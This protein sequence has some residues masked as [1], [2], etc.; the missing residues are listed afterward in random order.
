MAR[1][2]DE[3]LVF[4]GGIRWQLWR[5]WVGD[6]CPCGRKNCRSGLMDTCDRVVVLKIEDRRIT[7]WVMRD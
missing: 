6:K 2:L 5:G 1:W 4:K 7:A 3:Y